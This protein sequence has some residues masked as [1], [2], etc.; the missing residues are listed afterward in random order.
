MRP[1]TLYAVAGCPH[2]EAAR[3]YLA[4]R[5]VE[6]LEV[7]V[8]QDPRALHRVMVYGG[9]PSVPVIEVGDEIL[10]GFDPARLDELLALG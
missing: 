8:R 10:V 5:D 2:C 4:A 9:G 6:F 7:D 3:A 1:V